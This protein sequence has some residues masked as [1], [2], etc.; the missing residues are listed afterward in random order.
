M[1]NIQDKMIKFFLK[2]ITAPPDTFPGRS[3]S[4]AFLEMEHK[5]LNKVL[6]CYGWDK[7]KA[8]IKSK[9]LN[10]SRTPC[11]KSHCFN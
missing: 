7:S 10:F 11:F 1:K 8:I 4:L 3:V 9:I 6:L 5:G 2:S